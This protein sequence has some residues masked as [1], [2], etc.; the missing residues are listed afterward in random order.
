MRDS[1]SSI[2]F[3]NDHYDTV[4]ALY[5]HF[6]RSDISKFYEGIA[7]KQLIE[8]RWSGHLNSIKA[9]DKEVQRVLRCLLHTSTERSVKVEHRTIYLGLYHQVCNASFMLFNKILM[10][11]L[12]ILEIAIETFQSY[13]IGEIL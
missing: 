2:P 4:S 8:T 1:L 3:I 10:E 11:V 12:E 6:K 9:I 7:L 13:P 5:K